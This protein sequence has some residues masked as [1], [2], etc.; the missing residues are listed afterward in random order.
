MLHTHEIS[1]NIQSHLFLH[2]DDQFETLEPIRME[3]YLFSLD[4]NEG[5]ADL[6]D[7]ED[8]LGEPKTKS[9]HDETH[10]ATD[11]SLG[12]TSA[13]TSS[14]EEQLNSCF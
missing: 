12:S 7:V 2:T 9:S 1:P 10:E 6:F 13:L 3:D 11:Y 14:F 5:I 4:D 8:L